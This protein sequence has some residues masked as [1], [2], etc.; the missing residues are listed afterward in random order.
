MIKDNGVQ[1]VIVDRSRR[2]MVAFSTMVAFEA[3]HNVTCHAADRE[4]P[5]C[6][7]QLGYPASP[8]PPGT[9]P[10]TLCFLRPVDGV[11]GIE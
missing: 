10:V 1:R 6:Q 4:A 5:D 2:T 11:M 8:E 9:P 7:H 3:C